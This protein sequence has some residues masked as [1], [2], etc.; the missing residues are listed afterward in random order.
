M[1]LTK[2]IINNFAGKQRLQLSFRGKRRIHLIKYSYSKQPN[3]S[4]KDII[5]PNIP[6]IDSSIYIDYFNDRHNNI[7]KLD[8]Y[9]YAKKYNQ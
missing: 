7:C 1:K 6:E 4:S 5:K 9:I 3:K 2:R 8:K